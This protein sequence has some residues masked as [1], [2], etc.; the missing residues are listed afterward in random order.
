MSTYVDSALK[1]QYCI[2]E[3]AGFVRPALFRVEY[4]CETVFLDPRV[5]TIVNFKT[6]FGAQVE[7]ERVTFR[8]ASRFYFYKCVIK[9]KY[10]TDMPGSFCSPIADCRSEDQ[11]RTLL[12]ANILLCRSF[13]GMLFLSSYGPSKFLKTH[14]L[15]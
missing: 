1:I 7:M 9:T 2:H 10:D 13:R 11:P 4:Q 6:Y 8:P 3:M 15:L 5:K 12:P 14:F